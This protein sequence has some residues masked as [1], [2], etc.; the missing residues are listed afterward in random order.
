MNIRD[1]LMRIA[2]QIPGIPSDLFD[3]WVDARQIAATANIQRVEDEARI[4]THPQDMARWITKP[5]GRRKRPGAK[6]R[7]R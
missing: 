1:V 7:K 3:W 2:S 6:G 4:T 5:Q